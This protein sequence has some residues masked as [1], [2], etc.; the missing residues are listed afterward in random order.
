MPKNFQDSFYER[1]SQM[2]MQSDGY[3]ITGLKPSS[4]FRS[5]KK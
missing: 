2:Y 3:N 1:V 4:C 5:G